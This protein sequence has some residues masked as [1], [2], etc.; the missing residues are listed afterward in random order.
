[1]L[2][3]RHARLFNVRCYSC[4]REVAINTR[5]WE[6]DP[7]RRIFDY[8][9]ACPYC[10]AEIF[11][12][13]SPLQQREFRAGAGLTSIEPLLVNGDAVNG[14]RVKANSIPL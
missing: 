1:M 11:E 5:T 7:K 14:Q 13:T 10:A 12:C 8:W 6:I 3:Q 9:G 4:K 2:V